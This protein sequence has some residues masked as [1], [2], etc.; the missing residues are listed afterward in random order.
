MSGSRIRRKVRHSAVEVWAANLRLRY[1][2]VR[3]S[4]HSG[5]RALAQFRRRPGE[6]APPAATEP[7][8]LCGLAADS[9]T[10]RVALVSSFGKARAVAPPERCF[11][12]S[13][14][15]CMAINFCCSQPFSQ[16]SGRG[17]R[18]AVVDCTKGVRFSFPGA[19]ILILGQSGRR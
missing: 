4:R 1:H 2:R 19:V 15:S 6:E 10:G 16:K 18:L 14:S 13:A 17:G 11:W 3:P 12:E 8:L 7:L 5:V 9:L